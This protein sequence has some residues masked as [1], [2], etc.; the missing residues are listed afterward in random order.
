MCV[1]FMRSFYVIFYY[2]SLG[3]TILDFF[4]SYC[5]LVCSP[6]YTTITHLHIPLFSIHML[7]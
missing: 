5:A 4:F 2:I 7:M 1:M 3:L 6:P